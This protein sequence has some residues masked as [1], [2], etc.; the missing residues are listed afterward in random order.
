MNWRSVVAGQRHHRRI[1]VA[2]QTP[3]AAGC[4]AKR[5]RLPAL[6]QVTAPVTVAGSAARDLRKADRA[7]VTGLGRPPGFMPR[8]PLRLIGTL[9]KCVRAACSRGAVAACLDPRGAV[10]ETAARAALAR[11]S[12]KQPQRRPGVGDDPVV[13]GRKTRPIA[14]DRC[15]RARKSSRRCRCARPPGCGWPTWCRCPARSP[16]PA[17]GVAYRAVSAVPL[18][19]SAGGS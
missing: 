5:A 16:R 15:R 18:A 2:T 17:R 7:H 19:R 13:G 14:W 10:G 8:P 3:E 6:S 4:P 1:R 12:T 9:S 11:H